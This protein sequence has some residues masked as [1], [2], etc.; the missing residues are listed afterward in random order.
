MIEY[1][2]EKCECCG[3]TTTYIIG[4]DGGTVDIVKNIALF[5]GRKGINC[6]HPRKEM[7][8]HGLSSNQVGNLSRPI[9]K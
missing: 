6:V 3:Q 8:G 5:I 4:I 2:P 9:R 1:K 7:E